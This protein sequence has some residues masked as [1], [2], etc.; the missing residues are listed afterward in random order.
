M[1]L[2]FADDSTVLVLDN[3][4]EA[5]TYCEGIDVE[6]GVYVFVDERGAV[7]QP[8][9]TIPNSRYSLGPL[10]SVASGRFTLRPTKDRRPD[11]LQGIFDGTCS[12]SRGR[13]FQRERS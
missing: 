11:L 5:N 6:D 1:I 12:I 9:F 13:E 2:A 3:I 8:V 10:K 7:M 4:K